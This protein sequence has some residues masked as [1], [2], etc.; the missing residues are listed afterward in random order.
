MESQFDV[1]VRE[2]AFRG[3]FKRGRQK[4]QI[5][6]SNIPPSLRAMARQ[7]QR[8]L[9]LQFPITEILRSLNQQFPLTPALSP[10]RGRIVGSPRACSPAKEFGGTHISLSSFRDLD[11]SPRIELSLSD[12]FIVQEKA[13]GL[14]DFAHQFV[15][16]EIAFLQ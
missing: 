16:A 6:T 7:G 4:L 2:P 1:R 9:K 3:L 11:G 14:L 10:G 15:A 8:S 12:L 5:P 13:D